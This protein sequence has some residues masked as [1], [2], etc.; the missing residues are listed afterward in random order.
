LL[1]KY[2]HVADRVEKDLT[3]QSEFF[4]EKF[5]FGWQNGKYNL[6]EPVSFNTKIKSNIKENALHWYAVLA[7]LKDTAEQ[8]NYNFNLLVEKPKDKSLFKDFENA[9]RLIEETSS[10][11]RIVYTEELKNY[12]EELAET[13]K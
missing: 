11:K 6:V 8:K 1:K 10:P 4:S 13:I 9:L 2:E 3:I 12:V 7:R 5:S